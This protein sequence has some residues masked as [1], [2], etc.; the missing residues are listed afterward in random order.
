M[1]ELNAVISKI[2]YYFY[3]L[4]FLV[5]FGFNLYFYYPKISEIVFNSYFILN[6]FWKSIYINSSFAIL[7]ILIIKYKDL[8]LPAEELS[9]FRDE[10][11]NKSFYTIQNLFFI[12]NFV[13]II[14]GLTLHLFIMFVACIISIV[15]TVIM[16]KRQIENNKVYGLMLIGLI[17]TLIF[18]TYS[19]FL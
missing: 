9:N 3:I 7:L 1:N 8:T 6:I 10:N 15:F 14:L 13:G 2:T 19:I 12:F 5:L 16:L 17:E 4:V 18:I 11:E